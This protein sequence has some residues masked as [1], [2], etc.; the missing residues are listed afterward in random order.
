MSQHNLQAQLE[1]AMMTASGKALYN[2]SAGG[3][4]L[5]WGTAIP[6]DGTAGYAVGCLFINTGG[7]STTTNLY[8]NRGSATSCAFKAFTSVA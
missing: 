4:M 6:T 3:S 2:P 5:A 1:T 8:T 7:T